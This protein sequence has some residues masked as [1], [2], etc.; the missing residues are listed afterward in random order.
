[1]N[2]SFNVAMVQIASSSTKEDLNERKKEHIGIMEQYIAKTIMFHPTTDMIVFPELYITGVDLEHWVEMAEDIDTGLTTNAVR[3]LAKKYGVHIVPGSIFEKPDVKCKAPYNTMTIISPEGN[4]ILKYQKTSIPRPLEPSSPSALDN[5]YPVAV[6][7]GVKIGGLICADAYAPEGARWLTL[8]GAEVIIKP[9]LQDE[10][11]GTADLHACVCR[12]RSME[13][14]NFMVS[15]NQSAPMGMGCSIATNPEGEIVKY[16][17]TR[18]ST[19][20]IASLNVEE[21]NKARNFGSFGAFHF[22]KNWR[23]LIVEGTMLWGPSKEDII[24]SQLFKDYQ[25]KSPATPAELKHY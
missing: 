12:V 24:N 17:E 6:V 22:L 11:I 15:V 20:M 5:P 10:T 3:E 7:N 1:M 14:Q 2:K 18:A 8:N 19:V 13:N 25:G 23:D 4:I 21:L 9:T 16:L